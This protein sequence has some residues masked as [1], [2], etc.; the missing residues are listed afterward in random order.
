M[1][2]KLK[3]NTPYYDTKMYMAY[4]T[5]WSLK[6]VN[7]LH[8]NLH[9]CYCSHIYK[10]RR[11]WSTRDRALLPVFRSVVSRQFQYHYFKNVIYGVNYR[12]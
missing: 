2:N 1:T 3:Q 6:I 12:R 7:L 9:L 10:C 4:Q 11:T 8:T 5:Q